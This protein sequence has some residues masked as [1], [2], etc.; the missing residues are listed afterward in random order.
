MS[1]KKTS[2]KRPIRDLL[3]EKDAFLTTSEKA[4]EY[5]LRHTKAFITAAVAVVL[6]IVALAVYT[7]YQKS[8][9]VE[10]TLAFEQ[11]L[12]LATSQPDDTEAGLS[13]L[14]KVRGDYQGRQGSRL[15][16][17]ALVNI[18]ATRKEADKA[19]PLAENLLQTLKPSEISLKPLLL[20]SLGGLY[21]S[22]QDFQR[23]S[24]SYEAIL[25]LTN[26][27]PALRMETLMAL[28]RVKAAAGQKDEA[29]EF[30]QTVIKDFPLSFKSYLANAKVAEL[31]GEAT[32]YPLPTSG[33]SA[34]TID[35]QSGAD[36]ENSAS[37]AAAPATKSDDSSEA[38]P[39]A[40]DETAESAPEETES[41]ENAPTGE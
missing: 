40:N 12:E 26:L 21:E 30:Y 9:E 22:S 27:E 16:A 4:F 11:A 35:G 38:A 25:A 37:E 23:A 5:I 19:L 20:N 7:K 28:G 14:E 33:L 34:L 31:K 32:P 18:Y 39:M 36:K 24:K 29:I 1:E 10:S 3:Q 13:A 17:Y 15:A 41:P 8:A 2:D 6:C